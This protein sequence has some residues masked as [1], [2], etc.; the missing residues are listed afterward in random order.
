ME[1]LAGGA[2]FTSDASDASAM[3]AV[4]RHVLDGGLAV[5]EARALGLEVASR[6]TWDNTA[7]LHEQVYA[8]AAQRRL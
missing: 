8:E 2:A 1:E 7:A 4:I 3:A 5:D 6:F